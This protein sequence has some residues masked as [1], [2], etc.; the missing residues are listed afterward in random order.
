MAPRAFLIRGLKAGEPD[1]V[2]EKSVSASSASQAAD[3]ASLDGFT[4][5]RVMPT[6]GTA[7]PPLAWKPSELAWWCRELKTLIGAGMTVVE[8]LETLEA[9]P[10]T[11]QTTPKA[12]PKTTPKTP[13]Q[14]LQHALLTRLH[15]G[16]S[17]SQAMEGAGG[18]PPVLLASVR[19]AE[20]TSGLEGALDDFLKYH[21]L[22]EALR[23]R[24]ISAAMY[25]LLVCGVGFVIC[26]FL[27]L[28]VLP[29]FAG[30]LET[31]PAAMGGA[32]GLLIRLSGWMSSHTGITLLGVAALALGLV[33]LWR[34]GHVLRAALGLAQAL[35]PV[36]RA[37]RA[38]ELAQLFQALAL[39]YRGG[40]PLE[41]ALDV[42][43]RAA[44]LRAGDLAARLSICQQALLRGQSVATALEA[45]A[46][47]DTVSRR[48]LAVGERSGRLDTVL[49][50]IAL[51]HAQT[52]SDFV[53]R[54]MRVLEPL[55]L[56]LVAATI[57]GVVVLMYL[58]IFDIATG[59]QA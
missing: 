52:F 47:T 49:E 39:L 18:F 34:A 33:G 35:G 11:S 28:G 50:V 8:A 22:L 17:L 46:L 57:G 38:F 4:V 44:E 54:L 23:R 1:Q 6:P 56:L 27:L 16:Q 26:T 51:R 7:P 12:A 30:I 36:A 42:C 13:R 21:E 59:L 58:P 45:G 10:T 3:I 32:S 14:A 43:R 24:V 2:V 29:R 53:D 19:A 55:L 48:L 37:L 20:R 5:L 31:S 25:P 9:Q 41:E 15:Q 40:Y